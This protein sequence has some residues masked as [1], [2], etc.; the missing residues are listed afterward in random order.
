MST[1]VRLNKVLA[2]AGIC[3]RRKADLLIS[4]GLVAVNN[5]TVTELGMMVEPQKDRITVRG[6]VIQPE[7][8]ARKDFT[9][10]IMNKPVQVV[11][12]VS[13]PQGRTTVMDL[14]P[15]N[16]ASRRL[17]PVGRLDFFSQGLILLTND[18]ELTHRLT[19]PSW[20]HP[21]VYRVQVRENVTPEQLRIMARGMILRD[22]QE[23][24]PVQADIVSSRPGSTILEMTLIQG[25]NRQIRRM[26]SD[27]GLTILSLTRIRQ[28][29]LSI[30]G[31]K[32]GKCRRLT[33]REVYSLGKSVGL[34]RQY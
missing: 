27:L 4:Q 32:T 8:P 22:G 1:L 29:P 21:K 17:F 14:L 6:K 20:K 10:I 34:S 2:G 18:G 13:D 25:L 31:L 26:C 11:T 28:G 5:Q 23:L 16:L 33:A 24:A 19:H 15:P 12:T 30:Q 9:Y 3:S 7:S